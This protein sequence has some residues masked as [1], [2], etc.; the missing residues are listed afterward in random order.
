VSWKSEAGHG[1]IVHSQLLLCQPW[2][3]CTFVGIAGITTDIR[4][5]FISGSKYLFAE[6]RRQRPGRVAMIVLSDIPGRIDT[7]EEMPAG[8]KCM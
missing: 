6:A 2:P 5:L 1:H 4:H 3:L 7:D 8:S